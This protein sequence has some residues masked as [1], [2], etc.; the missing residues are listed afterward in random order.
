MYLTINHH[1]YAR[2]AIT[3]RYS[4]IA[5]IAHSFHIPK[6]ALGRSVVLVLGDE[7]AYHRL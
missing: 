5:R 1:N 6:D 7:D 3:T 2:N 4:L